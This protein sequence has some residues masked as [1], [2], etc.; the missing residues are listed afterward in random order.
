MLGMSST[1]TR[2]FCLGLA[3]LYVT[4]GCASGPPKPTMADLLNRAVGTKTRADFI[5]QLGPPM[6]TMQVDGDEFFVY[7]EAVNDPLA[8]LGSGLSSAAAG[9][10]GQTYSPPPPAQRTVILRFDGRTGLLKGWSM[11]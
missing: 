3:V 2:R 7:S 5:Q 10:R 8:N 6:R 9:Y 1:R 11:R 4:A